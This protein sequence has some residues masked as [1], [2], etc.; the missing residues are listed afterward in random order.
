MSADAVA[1]KLLVMSNC[2]S[3]FFLPWSCAGAASKCHQ[4]SC[5]HKFWCRQSVLKPA[6][7]AVGWWAGKHQ[8]W[9]CAGAASKCH[10]LSCP[11]E[12]WCRQ[13]VLKPAAVAV[14]WWAGK[15]QKWS[16]F[17]I[18]WFWYKIEVIFQKC[19]VHAMLEPQSSPVVGSIISYHMLCLY[20]SNYL[21]NSLGR[22]CNEIE[23][24]DTYM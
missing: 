14:G 21:R 20:S 16:S 10:Q 6:A 24:I 8:K 17:S 13:S 7:V 9:S 19:W 5:P 2:H 15:H 18:G 12:F 4:L 3:V 11:H 23:S 1:V 22:C